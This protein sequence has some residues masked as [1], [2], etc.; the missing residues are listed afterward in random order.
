MRAPEART[1]TGVWGNAPRESLKSRSSEIRLS[2]FEF[3]FWVGGAGGEEEENCL[4]CPSASYGLD[5]YPASLHTSAQVIVRRSKDVK[6]SHENITCITTFNRK[7][8][9]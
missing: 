3:F 9:K 6:A 8:K 5:N 1:V 7:A 2:F 4:P